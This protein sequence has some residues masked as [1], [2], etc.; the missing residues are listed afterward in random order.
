MKETRMDLEYR[1]IQIFLPTDTPAVYDV[2]L[3]SETKDIRCN[4]PVFTSAKGTC[5]H[6]RFVQRR[7]DSNSGHYAISVP[8]HVTEEETLLAAKTPESFRKFVVKYSHIEVI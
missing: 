3:C 4:C 1:T 5:K 7:M 2:E 6:V 8:E